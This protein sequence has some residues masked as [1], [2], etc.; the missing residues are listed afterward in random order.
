MTLDQI[1]AYWYE[2]Y[3]LVVGGITALGGLLAGG[4]VLWNKLQPIIDNLNFLKKKAEDTT[5]EDITQQLQLLNMDTQIT[6]LKAKISNS[7]ISDEL[8]QQYITQLATLETFKAK[9]EQGLATVEETTSK[10]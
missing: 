8:K 7:A 2:Y 10:F 3:P 4:L 9:L 6:D 5:K 1:Q